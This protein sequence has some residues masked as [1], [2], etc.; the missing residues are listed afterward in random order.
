MASP[1]TQVMI[2]SI[3][4]IVCVFFLPHA[5]TYMQHTSVDDTTQ[6]LNVKEK[7]PLNAYMRY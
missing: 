2:F 5:G 3:E 7:K 1:T 6:P 4:K